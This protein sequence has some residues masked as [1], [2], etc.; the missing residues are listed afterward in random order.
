MTPAPATGRRPE[1]LCEVCDS[2]FAPSHPR[3]R[4]CSAACAL[5]LRRATPKG[6]RAKPGKVTVICETCGKPFASYRSERR[7]FCSLECNSPSTAPEVRDRISTAKTKTGRQTGRRQRQLQKA[8]FTLAAKGETRCRNCGSASGLNLHHIIP[9]SMWKAG[10]TNPLNGVPL[11]VRC[12]MGW[13]NRAV[14]IYRDI[15]TAAE[16]ACV[17]G[18]KLLGQEVGAWLDRRYP[19]RRKAAA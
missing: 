12:H 6:P 4:T 7:R 9:R 1:K 5:Q 3:V 16:W 18:A 10:I 2:S 19:P 15:F 14:T 13:H 11:C 8:G 17:S